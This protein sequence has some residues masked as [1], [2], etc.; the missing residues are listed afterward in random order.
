VTVEAFNTEHTV[1][2]TLASSG[3]E[4]DVWDEYVIT[5]DMLSPGASF[6]FALWYSRDRATAWEVLRRSV[7]VG[8]SVV[9]SID[10]APQLN[11]RI[12]TIET[13]ADGHGA[14]MMTVTGRDLA[15]VALDF[16]AD[17]TIN[18]VGLRLED[19]LRRVFASVN[20]PFR[21]TTADAAREVTS[22]RSGRRGGAATAARLTALDAIASSPPAVASPPTQPSIVAL[23]IASPLGRLVGIR[24]DPISL[25]PIEDLTAAG[26][27]AQ[28]SAA[29]EASRIRARLRAARNKSVIVDE[30]HPKP[31]ERVWHFAEA[32]VCRLGMRLW[33]APDAANGVTVVADR[34]DDSQEPT[35]A[36]NRVLTD[37]V[38][39]SPSNNV[40]KGKESISI[41][42]VPTSVS[43]YTNTS[44]GDTTAGRSR[45]IV[46]NTR[47]ADDVVTRG[48]VLRPTPLQPRYIRSERSRVPQRSEQEGER[49]ITDAMASFRTYTATVRGHGQ[50]VDGVDR[51]FAINTTA[52]VVDS[53]CSDPDG[54]AL[55]EVMLM[56][57]VEF[58]RA[59]VAGT[60]GSGTQTTVNL[61]PLGAI[62]LTPTQT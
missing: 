39:T 15:G 37:G 7:K 20:V 48:F 2:L 25:T 28:R 17:P 47:L 23:G 27:A 45:A 22:K 8:D 10:G 57:R 41:R 58:R 11:G 31:G 3:V 59:R 51:L 36:F 19:A 34:P 54:N 35:F 50:R 40:L 32:I 24:V 18:V 6:T 55:D 44:R 14:R 38:N 60:G 4:L 9:L 52:R 12:D 49:I 62:D 21:M 42:G 56:T 43:V 61:V 26:R 53:V 46:Q 1:A 29:A 30:A 16:D 33:V 5:L 13:D